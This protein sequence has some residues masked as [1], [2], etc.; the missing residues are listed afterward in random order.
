MHARTIVR[1]TTGSTRLIALLSGAIGIAS[2]AAPAG[3][4]IHNAATDFSATSNPNGVW[5][6]GHTSSTL[7]SAF[8]PF[9]AS[10]VSLGLDYWA[11]SA[12]PIL[13]GAL[14]N[15]SSGTIFYGSSAVV[16]PGQLALHPGQLGEYAVARFT[17]VTAGT[18]TFNADFIGQDRFVSIVNVHLLVNSGPVFGGALAGYHTTASSGVFVMALLPGDTIDAAVG[19]GSNGNYFGDSTGVDFTVSFVPAPGAA[20][21]LGV[22]GMVGARRRRSSRDPLIA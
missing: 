19:Y 22:A 12:G 11:A 8:T 1:T 9:A 2:L 3:A 16:E 10:G 7:G 21:L 17:V 6:L 5:T 15:P 20:A 18:Y 13:P 14:H 4:S